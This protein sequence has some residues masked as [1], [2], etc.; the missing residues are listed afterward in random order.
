MNTPNDKK[1]CTDHQHVGMPCHCCPD[2]QWH[3]ELDLNRR[4][5]LATAAIGGAVL[6]GLSWANL[7][8]ASELQLPK[9]KGRKTLKVL[10]ILVWDHPKRQPAGDPLSGFLP[11]TEQGPQRFELLILFSLSRVEKSDTP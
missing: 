5:F 2:N 6:G 4:D 7:A 3:R 10:P 8:G 11:I 9:P 1:Q